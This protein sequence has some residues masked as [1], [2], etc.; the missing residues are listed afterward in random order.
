MQDV[1]EVRE[2]SK[3]CNRRRI[4]LPAF[5]LVRVMVYLL[6][7][8][9]SGKNR[10]RCETGLYRTHGYDRVPKAR[11]GPVRERVAGG[12]D[13]AGR[14]VPAARAHAAAAARARHARRQVTA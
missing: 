12:A 2:V 5:L 1:E 13:Q 10:F 4:L 11:S 3:D 7:S 9:Y 6:F 14:P 8:F